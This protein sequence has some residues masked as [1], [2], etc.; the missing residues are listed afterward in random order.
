MD[1]ITTMT[2]NAML[3]DIEQMQQYL[4]YFKELLT[5]CKE[6]LP[7]VERAVY[8]KYNTTPAKEDA[9]D[10]KAVIR[11]I[12]GERVVPVNITER[13]QLKP[14]GEQTQQDAR[15]RLDD[16]IDW[17]QF[18]LKDFAQK[19]AVTKKITIPQVKGLLNSYGFAKVSDITDPTQKRLFH[20][21]LIEIAKEQEEQEE[22]PF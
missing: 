16:G 12:N 1:K 5:K 22:K 7:K 2:T 8:D 11:T 9:T 4:N 19:Y 17:E 6:D 15:Q 14:Q 13:Q 20:D 18:D 10:K 21:A 3:K